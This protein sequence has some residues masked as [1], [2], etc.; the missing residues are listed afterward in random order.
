M[1][2]HPSP[3]FTDLNTGMDKARV[4]A[5][6]AFESA[7][8]GVYQPCLMARVHGKFDELAE[9]KVGGSWGHEGSPEMA[10]GC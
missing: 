8:E 2:E 1:A 6:E 5:G 7:V 3:V 10:V 4:G 9:R